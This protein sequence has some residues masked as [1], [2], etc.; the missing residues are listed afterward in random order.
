MMM[1]IQQKELAE[2]SIILARYFYENQ[3]LDDAKILYQEAIKLYENELT[4]DSGELPE[5]E[6]ALLPAYHGLAR[7]TLEKKDLKQTLCLLEKARIRSLF[8]TPVLTEFSA[9]QELIWVSEM[10]ENS[11]IHARVFLEKKDFSQAEELLFD[12]ENM[13]NR[14]YKR[15]QIQ[16][17]EY[18][19]LETWLN[20][21]LAGIYGQE[22]DYLQNLGKKMDSDGNTYQ[23]YRDRS[24]ALWNDIIENPNC[25]NEDRYAYAVQL[26]HAAEAC[27]NAREKSVFGIAEINDETWNEKEYL[28]KALSVLKKLPKQGEN[29]E[30]TI[31]H[32]ILKLA[33]VLEVLDLAFEN[34]EKT[35]NREQISHLYQEA[36]LRGESVGIKDAERKE[37]MKK[38]YYNQSFWFVRIGK[39]QL[40]IKSFGNYLGCN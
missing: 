32:L 1:S 34:E 11:R 18:E 26:Q 6:I 28:E 35:E 36:I 17:E 23:N 29:Q 7:I 9:E 20:V 38:I 27:E 2:Y 22:A 31:L 24:F 15:G 14:S 30:K 13:L 16:I 33:K 5:A 10:V 19:K 37:L 3:R 12:G 40:G 25:T 21:S 4:D 8:M 39:Y